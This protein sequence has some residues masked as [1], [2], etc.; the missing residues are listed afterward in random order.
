MTKKIR[1]IDTSGILDHKDPRTPIRTGCYSSGFAPAICPICGKVV[2]GMQKDI[3]KHL[4]RCLDGHDYQL[5]LGILNVF[6]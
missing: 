2:G 3:V 5:W 6:D 1:S 4:N